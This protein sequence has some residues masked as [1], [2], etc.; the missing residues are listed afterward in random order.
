[1]LFYSFY[2]HARAIQ[3]QGH[4]ALPHKRLKLQQTL[5]EEMIPEHFPIV[6][7]RILLVY[8]DILAFGAMV[9]DRSTLLLYC[10]FW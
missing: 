4:T 6:F 7:L 3:P 5:A 1:M 8:E 10:H 9:P 2:S